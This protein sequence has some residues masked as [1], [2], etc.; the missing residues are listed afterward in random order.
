MSIPVRKVGGGEPHVAVIGGVHGDERSSLLIQHVLEERGT[1][2]GTL[3]LVGPVNEAAWRNGTRYID[4]DLNRTYPEPDGSTYESRIAQDL[5]DLVAPMDVV[6]DIHT[7]RMTTQLTVVRTS[8]TEY[9]KY[10]RPDIIWH[11]EADKE[12]N[13]EFEK[14]LG[15]NL[16][17]DG[18]DNFVVE[19]PPV[20][21]I[22]ESMIERCIDGVLNVVTEAEQAA[23]NIPVYSREKYP[24]PFTGIFMPDHAIMTRVDEGERVGTLFSSTTHSEEIETADDGILLQRRHQSWIERGETIYAIGEPHAEG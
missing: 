3:H 9:V 7:F 18:T 10:F 16:A 15:L 6:I 23:Q 19:L 8:R 20:E 17:L 4:E 21:E 1:P 22:S 5:L 14:T 12:G 24:A 2:T 11:I 13:E